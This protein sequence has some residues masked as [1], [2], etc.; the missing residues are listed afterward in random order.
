MEILDILTIL[1]LVA[2]VLYV[3]DFG[4]K[5]TVEGFWFNKTNEKNYKI[6]KVESESS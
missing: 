2:I 5:C 1:L 6:N 4:Y 3:V